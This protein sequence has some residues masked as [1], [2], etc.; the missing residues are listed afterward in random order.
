MSCGHYAVRELLSGGRIDADIEHAER[1][2]RFQQRLVVVTPLRSQVCVC[3]WIAVTRKS[4]CLAERWKARVLMW[5]WSKHLP[6]QVHKTM[7]MCELSA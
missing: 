2:P 4:V 7:M 3:V 5:C 6:P 1:L